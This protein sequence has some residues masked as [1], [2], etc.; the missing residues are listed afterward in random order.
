MEQ[1][2]LPLRRG[3]C[4]NGDLFLYTSLLTSRPFYIL[5]STS[6]T[7]TDEM[8]HFIAVKTAVTLYMCY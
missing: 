8:Q 7:R 5:I 2:D 1:W 4:S 3:K 6:P